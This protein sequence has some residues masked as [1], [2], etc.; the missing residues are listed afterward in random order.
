MRQFRK[1]G[2]MGIKTRLFI[3]L[4]RAQISLNTQRKLLL[5]LPPTPA[6]G[7]CAGK[8]TSKLCHTV[9]CMIRSAFCFIV[10]C[11]LVSFISLILKGVLSNDESNLHERSMVCTP[12]R[13]TTSARADIRMNFVSSLT[14]WRRN[15]LLIIFSTCIC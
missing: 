13:V 10:Y 15:F 11:L 6:P 12:F 8:E 3:G 7:E 9:F 5:T 1:C 2:T 4:L 14:I